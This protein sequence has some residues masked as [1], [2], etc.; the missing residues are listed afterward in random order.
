[1]KKLQMKSKR[2]LMKNCHDS[3]QNLT[4]ETLRNRFESLLL[5]AFQSARL[6]IC[7]K[8][9]VSLAQHRICASKID[10]LYMLF[11]SS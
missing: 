9:N 7:A 4:L 6:Y 3:L 2:F 10:I 5:F 8:Q 1:M 11:S